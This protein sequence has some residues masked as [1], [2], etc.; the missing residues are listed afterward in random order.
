V[1]GRTSEE[2]QDPAQHRRQRLRWRSRRGLLELELLLAPFVAERLPTLPEAL[3][4]EYESLLEFDDLDIHDWLTG[5]GSPPEA[6]ARVV[7]DIARR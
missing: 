2:Q 1:T 5:R 3:L 6:V 7:A 4:D